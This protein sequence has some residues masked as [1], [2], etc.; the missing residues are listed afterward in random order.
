VRTAV[1]LSIALGALA[2]EPES[3]IGPR[4]PVDAQ[5]IDPTCVEAQ[6]TEDS[7]DL[8]FA[9]NNGDHHT[10]PAPIVNLGAIGDAPLG[11]EAA[12]PHRLAPWEEPFPC[13]WT[14]T[15]R[16]VPVACPC[17]TPYGVQ[18]VVAR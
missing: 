9:R 10:E 16:V 17:A 11:R 1:G 5:R 8:T 13:D 15:C 3:Q 18:P 6:A 12:P 14:N 4:Y 2:C 7:F